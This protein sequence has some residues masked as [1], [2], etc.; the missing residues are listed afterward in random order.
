MRDLIIKL[1][2]EYGDIFLVELKGELFIFRAITPKE[3]EDIQFY[4][5]AN[6]HAMQEAIC[7]LAVVHPEEYDFSGRGAAGVPYTLFHEI[8]NASNF[9]DAK[10]PTQILEENR[11]HIRADF[12]EQAKVFISQ[13]FTN[14]S[15][16]EMDEWDVEK[17]MK[18]LARAEWALK[19]IHQ[20]PIEFKQKDENEDDDED[21]EEPLT[22]SEQGEELRHEGVDPM[23]A[24]QGEIKR[25]QNKDG[26]KVYVQFPMI[27]GTKLFKNEGV[28]DRVREQVQRLSRG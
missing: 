24:L 16:E 23:I 3:L 20:L 26:K 10:K 18:Y 27:G 5:G 17:L 8:M 14:I 13:A 2:Q 6:D 22:L 28:L 1:K 9:D 15:F 21:K 25:E 11:Q 4:Y 19:E 7:H 12:L